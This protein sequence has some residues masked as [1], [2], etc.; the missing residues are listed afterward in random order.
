MLRL[1][2]KSSLNEALPVLAHGTMWALLH[3]CASGAMSRRVEAK[4][5]FITDGISHPSERW[6]W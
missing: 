2:R 6:A 1:L 5:E 4:V 3:C